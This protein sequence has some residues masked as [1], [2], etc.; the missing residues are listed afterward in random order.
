MELSEFATAILASVLEP[1]TLAGCVAAG[2]LLGRL[3]KA[4]GASTVWAFFVQYFIILP[5]VRAQGWTYAPEM[6][7]AALLAACLA[8]SIVYYLANRRMSGD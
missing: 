6:L 3:W 2:S 1:F 4:V 7:A 5:R 8:T